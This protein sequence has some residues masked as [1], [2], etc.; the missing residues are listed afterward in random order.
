[1]QSNAKS[2]LMTQ[3]ILNALLLALLSISYLSLVTYTPFSLLLSKTLI[4]S[5]LEKQAPPACPISS[6]TH[7]TSFFMVQPKQALLYSNLSNSWNMHARSN[8]P[9]K[10][11]VWKPSFPA[12]QIL[13]DLEPRRHRNSRLSQKVCPRQVLHNFSFSFWSQGR[14]VCAVPQV[15]SCV[16]RYCHRQSQPSMSQNKLFLFLSWSPQVIYIVMEADQAK[17]FLQLLILKTISLS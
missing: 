7:S 16:T 17:W 4:T 8:V 5:Y 11:H 6:S 12:H 2:S 10:S 15:P 3:V 1:M 9:S 13:E 14:R